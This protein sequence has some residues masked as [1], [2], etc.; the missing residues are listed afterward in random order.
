MPKK[1]RV[2]LPNHIGTAL[3]G[4]VLGGST[5]AAGGSLTAFVAQEEMKGSTPAIISSKTGN[6]RGK[7]NRIGHLGLCE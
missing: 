2:G 5:A 7:A 1:V 6:K 3:G 4:F